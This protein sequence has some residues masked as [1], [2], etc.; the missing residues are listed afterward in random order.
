MS[1]EETRSREVG[2][3][4]F[5]VSYQLYF[6]RYIISIDMFPCCFC[7]HEFLSTKNHCLL[8]CS[9]T[10]PKIVL[11]PWKSKRIVRKTLKV[12]TKTRIEMQ[13]S[14]FSERYE[15]LFFEQN[16]RFTHRRFYIHLLTLEL[17]VTYWRRMYCVRKIQ[18][19]LERNYIGRGEGYNMYW[20]RLNLPNLPCNCAYVRRP[21]AS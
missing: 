1:V 12:I 7:A 6:I 2:F 9:V 8:V 10:E 13:I 18:S 17:C 21:R 15:T 20:G 4:R 14:F 3:S 11:I 5:P 16:V 19:G